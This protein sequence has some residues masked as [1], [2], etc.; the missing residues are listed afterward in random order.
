SSTICS[1]QAFSGV[2]NTLPQNS[3]VVL[4]SASGASA[5]SP[6]VPLPHAA[7]PVAV[8]AAAVEMKVLRFMMDLLV[9]G[10]LL[11]AR[12]SGGP[13]RGARVRDRRVASRRHRRNGACS[14]RS[15]HRALH[16]TTC[17]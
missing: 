1:Y 10:E 4:P 9:I 6:G 5:R 13:G 2:V 14:G 17:W 12:G 8:A 15:P 3:T 11:G 16:R 7:S